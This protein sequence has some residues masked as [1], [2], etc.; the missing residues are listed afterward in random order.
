TAKRETSAPLDLI[1]IQ[2]APALVGG[3]DGASL[4]R[5]DTWLRLEPSVGDFYGA[6]RSNARHRGPTYPLLENGVR[7]EDDTFEYE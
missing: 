2:F 4:T 7:F 3:D 6:E 5:S 1:T